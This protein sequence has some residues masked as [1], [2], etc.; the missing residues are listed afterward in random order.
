M[1]RLRGRLLRG[2]SG[3]RGRR[4][5][6]EAAAARRPAHDARP[7]RRHRRPARR[8][9]PAGTDRRVEFARRRLRPPR[10]GPRAAVR[11]TRIDPP[12]I[13]PSGAA[14]FE[15]APRRRQL[16]HSRHFLHAFPIGTNAGRTLVLNALTER[17]LRT[18]FPEH[19]A[20]ALRAVRGGARLGLR[21]GP[22]VVLRL[23]VHRAFRARRWR[24]SRPPTRAPLPSPDT[25]GADS[26]PDR[27][28]IAA[29]PRCSASRIHRSASSITRPRTGTHPVRPRTR[30]PARQ[31]AAAARMGGRPS[32]ARP[33][34]RRGGCGSRPE[35]GP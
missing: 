5:T 1:G 34:T 7:L 28:S 3:R 18:R 35:A 17:D 11:P 16:A 10:T 19:G 6:P 2:A 31:D 29:R 15:P 20:D 4:A 8:R 33:R 25:H 21:S 26:R 12:R 32:G 22:V 14:P 27:R 24:R 23:R 13:G 9:Y 30:L